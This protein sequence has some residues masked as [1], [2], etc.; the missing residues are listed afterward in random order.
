MKYCFNCNRLTAGEPLF[1]NSC[2][3]SF[4]VKLCSRLHVNP[5]SAQVCSQCGSHDLS[6]PQPKVPFWGK[7]LLRLVPVGA[8]ILLVIVSLAFLADLLHELANRPQVAFVLA[9]SIG[10]LWWCWSQIPR[11]I[12]QFIYR[13]IKRRERN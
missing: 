5:R 12:R 13:L 9:V 4:D 6:T 1:C 3:G 8:A 7:A 2:G 10:F 11:S